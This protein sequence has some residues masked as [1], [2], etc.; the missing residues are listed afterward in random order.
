M[1]G[2]G[3]RAPYVERLAQR[4]GALRKG[5]ARIIAI[6]MEIRDIRAAYV[7]GSFARGSVRLRSDLDILIVRE[8]DLRRAERDLDVRRAFECA[9]GLDLIV[10]T[11]HEY[12]HVLPTTAFGQ[13]ILAESVSIYAA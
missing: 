4:E 11:P 12:A 3:A 9:V 8:T 7:F 10:V 6:C 1:D 13:T 5:V 2:F